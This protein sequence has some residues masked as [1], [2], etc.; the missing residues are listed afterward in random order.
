MGTDSAG[1]D[2][3]RLL[4]SFRVDPLESTRN[5][6]VVVHDCGQLTAIIVY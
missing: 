5:Q 1:V 3:T 2:S 6:L 4:A